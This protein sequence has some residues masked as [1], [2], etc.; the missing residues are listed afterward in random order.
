MDFGDTVLWGT[1]PINCPP[2]TR[3]RLRN[4]T[5]RHGT[6]RSFERLWIWNVWWRAKLRGWGKGRECVGGCC[7]EKREERERRRQGAGSRVERARLE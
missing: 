7:R 3:R 2:A 5:M 4:V 1:S 6:Y